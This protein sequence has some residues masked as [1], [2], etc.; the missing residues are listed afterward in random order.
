MARDEG[1]AGPSGMAVDDD[2]DDPVVRSLDVYVCNEFLGSG[3]QLYL[4]QHPL[5]PPW[6]PYDY[7]NVEKVR[8]KPNARRVEVELPLVSPV[9]VPSTAQ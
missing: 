5:R 9:P 4:F 6:R 2:D 1:E 8:M 7:G 3:S